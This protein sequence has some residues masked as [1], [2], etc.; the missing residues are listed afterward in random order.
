MNGPEYQDP[1]EYEPVDREDYEAWERERERGERRLARG[2]DC[3]GYRGDE[4]HGSHPMTSKTRNRSALTQQYELPHFAFTRNG[5]LIE[6]TDATLC[7]FES[8]TQTTNRLTGT[9]GGVRRTFRCTD[10]RFLMLVGPEE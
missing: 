10:N 4:S 2:T 6:L 9:I 3:G 8:E 7:V 1:I 5:K